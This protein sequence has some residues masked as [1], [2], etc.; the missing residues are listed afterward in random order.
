MNKIGLQKKM[1][2]DIY[3]RKRKYCSADLDCDYI[4]TQISRYCLNITHNCNRCA[5]QVHLQTPEYIGNNIYIANKLTLYDVLWHGEEHKI[6]QARDIVPY[7]KEGLQELIDN[8]KYYSQFDPPNGYGDV[9]SLIRFC[10]MTF[11]ACKENPKAY[12]EFSR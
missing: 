6:I 9:F 12:L 4:D 8:V 3:L 5:M 10:I 2:L 1:S 7:V 11:Y